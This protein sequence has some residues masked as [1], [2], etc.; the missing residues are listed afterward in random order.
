M[1]MTLVDVLAL[2]AVKRAEPDVVSAARHLDRVVRWVHIGE[3]P[4]IYDFLQGG[5]LLLMVGM[6]FAERLDNDRAQ[7][8]YIRGLAAGGLSGLMLELGRVFD[9]VPTAMV[10]EAERVGLP[11]I[12]LRR[13]TRYVEIT[14]DVHSAII[15]HHYALLSKAEQVGR[16]FTQL[17]MSGAGVRRILQQLAS[18]VC[19]PVM[20]E[21]SA[22]QII[23]V[24][25]HEAPLDDLLEGWDA[26]S[27]TG[28]D[29]HPAAGVMTSTGERP[30]VWISIVMRGELWGRIHIVELDT[31]I[32]EIDALALDRAAAALGMSLLA[33]RD[34]LHVAEHARSALIADIL[35]QHGSAQQVLQRARALGADLA[36]KRLAVASV[37]LTELAAGGAELSAAECQEVRVQA[38]SRLRDA[39]HRAGG[40]CL[41]A[42][43]GNRVLAIVGVPERRPIREDLDAIGRDFYERMRGIPGSGA[44]IGVS[45]PTRLEDVRRAIDEA[46][47]AARS[48]ARMGAYGRVCHHA[49]L[50]VNELLVQLADGPMLARFVEAQLQPLLDH[51][52]RRTV[53]LL[54]TLRAYLDTGGSKA[55]SARALHL[56]R[57]SLYHRLERISRLLGHDLDNPDARLRLTLALRGLEL[58]QQDKLRRAAD[59]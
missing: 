30:C 11:V 17:V 35:E 45:D 10:D 55:E 21:D 56:G 47:G 51:D 20:L 59:G 26:H 19:N 23:D 32:D 33:E 50:G 58:L 9:E 18:I 2:D 29:G 44:V 13:R 8:E 46:R 42:L 43:E 3:A 40:A 41:A 48:G 37:D 24:A 15:N 36:G 49:D 6:A 34:S 38:V 52:A 25:A 53:R 12:V 22:H 31:P 4:D 54:P 5:E 39:V 57:R 27:R 1:A 28:H 7:R 14:Q 16:D